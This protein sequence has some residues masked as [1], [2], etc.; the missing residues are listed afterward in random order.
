MDN[1]FIQLA[2]ILGLASVLGFITYKMKLPLLIAYLLG[3]LSI[4]FW[5][6]FDVKTSQALSFLPEIG[7]AFL[8]FL[9]GM[10]LDF[11]EIRSFGRPIIL[12][13]VLQII[14][15]T[16]MG[17]FLAQSFG[18][19]FLEAIFLGVGLSFS[20]TI[21][22]VKLLLDRKD[23][24]SLYGKLALGILLLEDLL[25]VVILL[26]LT[27]TASALGLG[28]T[29]AF[30][31]ATFMVK[32][33]ILFALALLLNRYI[34]G[35]IFKAVSASSELLFLTALAWCFIYVTFALSL[36]F[37]VVIGAFLAGVA[38]ANSHYHFQISGK[39][40]PMRDFFVALFFVYLGT[41]VNFSQI[42]HTFPLILTFTT[43]AVL[44]KPLMFLLLLGIFGFRKH[45]LFSTAINLSQISEFS[46]IVLLVG[47]EQGLVRDSILTVIASSA[48]LS[49][50]V[51]SVLIIK[52]KVIYKHLAKFLSLFETAGSRHFIE[53]IKQNE[54]LVGHVVVIG[55]HRVGGEVV[56]LLKKEKIPQIVLDF[57]PHLVE[58][59]LNLH[60][61]VVYGDMGDPEVLDALNLN[62]ARMVISTAPV[63]DDNKLLLEELRAKHKNIPV[64]LRADTSEDAKKLYSL[65][66]DYVI[67]PELLAG[68]VLVERLKEHLSDKEF[69]KDRARIELEKLERKTLA[70]E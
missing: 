50:I 61:P 32:A 51:S 64:I 69:F 25:A 7:L 47:V 23:L 15:T 34:L 44:V 10:E 18:F 29:Q 37:S 38:L 4:A 66:A 43:Y 24:S 1:I 67:I 46:L 13:G 20:S 27:S 14:I 30:P 59:L 5:G 54:Q 40:K 41:K 6:I 33:L 19:N 26:G 21:V 36:G 9:V 11:R 60:I 56:K 35:A 2:I 39:V 63:L 57:N 52:S 58:V 45:T 42:G 3:G 68:D 12:A 31:I 70:W 65:G 53:D 22:V 55:G 48:L 28:L 8:L 16:V 49:I 17:A 62:E